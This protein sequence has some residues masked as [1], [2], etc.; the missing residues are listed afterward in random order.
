MSQSYMPGFGND[1]ETL[2]ADYVDCW[3][4]LEKRFN[5]RP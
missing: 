1:F 3:S 4:G 2:D 5:G